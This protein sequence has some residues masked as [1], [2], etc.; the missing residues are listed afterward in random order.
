MKG[1]VDIEVYDNRVHYFLTLKRNI[2][3]IQGNSGSGKTVLYTMIRNYAIDG[4]KSGVTVKSDRECLALTNESRWQLDIQEKSNVVFFIDENVRYI[5]SPEFQVL[6]NQ[7][8]NYF[9]I[10][11]RE[12]FTNLT[13]SINEIYGF[14]ES[15]KY[16][17]TKR[18]YNEMY[19]IYDDGLE[20][21]KSNND[22][23]ID[24][25]LPH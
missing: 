22:N 12:P 23:E 11:S 6:A 21:L 20:K 4:A 10:I 8:P 14:R 2:T 1:K 16:R 18:V 15:G 25:R 13:Y 9:V 19:G 24:L 3:V 17:N 5:R 7:N